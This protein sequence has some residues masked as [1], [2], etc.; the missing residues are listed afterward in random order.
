MW[1]V[2]ENLQEKIIHVIPVVDG[3]TGEIKKPH[4]ED[5]FCDCSPSIIQ[6]DNGF[7]IVEHN[8]EQ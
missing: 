5:E 3:D 1:G 6:A 8:E 7:L 2:F 4:I